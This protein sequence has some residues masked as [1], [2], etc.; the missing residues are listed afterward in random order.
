[1]IRA[2]L[3]DFDGV[4]RLWPNSDAERI[5]AEFTLPSAALA[6]AAFT[7]ELLHEATTGAISDERWRERIAEMLAAQHGDRARAAVAA[8]IKLSGSLDHE[9]LEVLRQVRRTASVV[10]VTNA[11]SRLERDLDSLGIREVF[12]AIA[13]SSALGAVKP[14]AEIFERAAALVNV[15]LADCVFI[16]DQPRHLEAARAAG[17]SA[18]HHRGASETRRALAALGLPLD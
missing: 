2:V 11:T 10:L 17:V 14:Q 7:P 12:D 1:V 4:I 3:C 15:P 13:N 16:D 6:E 8:W 9:M 5:E 18:I